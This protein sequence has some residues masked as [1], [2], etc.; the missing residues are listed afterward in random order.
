MTDEE[1]TMAWRKILALIEA[2]G[3]NVE[4]TEALSMVQ[5]IRETGAV[6]EGVL[7]HPICHYGDASNPS[8]FS[9]PKRTV[10]K[11]LR[12]LGLP[13]LADL[14]KHD[15]AAYETA[16]ANARVAFDQF[17]EP[18]KIPVRTAYFMVEGDFTLQ[19]MENGKARV[20]AAE[21]AA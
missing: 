3:H 19:I 4:D 20:L 16:T 1:R 14:L 10:V 17:I 9:G 7:I 5:A 11:R 2:R 6:P 12:E 15:A 8:G 18:F 21:K 13:A